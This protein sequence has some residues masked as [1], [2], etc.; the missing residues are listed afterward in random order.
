MSTLVLNTLTQFV[1]VSDVKKAAN[2][3]RLQ[4]RPH[5]KDHLFHLGQT[6]ET[7]LSYWLYLC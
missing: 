4:Y 7:H 3:L 5:A 2:T 1:L 6:E